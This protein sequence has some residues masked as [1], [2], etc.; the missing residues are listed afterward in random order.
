MSCCGVISTFPI[1]QCTTAAAWPEHEALTSRI[2]AMC[3]Y[4][5]ML[6]WRL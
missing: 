2:K 6:A 3:I 5:H 1:E 4:M